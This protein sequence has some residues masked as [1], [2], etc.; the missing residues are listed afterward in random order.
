MS[1]LKM[2]LFVKKVE[3]TDDKGKK[4]KFN[5]YS[6]KMNL[7][8]DRHPEMIVSKWIRL[9]FIKELD[10]NSI[11]SA[12]TLYADSSDVDVPA[13]YKVVKLTGKNGQYKKSIEPVLDADGNLKYPSLPG[14]TL[15]YPCVWVRNFDR[16]EKLEKIEATQNQFETAEEPEKPLAHEVRK[17]PKDTSLNASDFADSKA[18]DGDKLPF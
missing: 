1:M 5:A 18:D 17:E 14:D 12:G 16:F 13:T 7:P 3:S 2:K 4:T 11:E 9:K 6:V 10:V 15:Q 8:L